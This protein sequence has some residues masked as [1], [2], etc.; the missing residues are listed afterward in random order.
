MTNDKYEGC[1]VYYGLWNDEADRIMTRYV[2]GNPA[3]VS[4]TRNHRILTV[5][6]TAASHTNDMYIV[7]HDLGCDLRKAGVEVDD[8]YARE[9]IRYE[10]R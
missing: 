3:I 4:A 1:L 6:F 9:V 10:S 7:L 5:T 8:T 2:N